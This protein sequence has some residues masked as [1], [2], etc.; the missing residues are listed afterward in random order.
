[1]RR[2]EQLQN[3]YK[4]LE[5]NFRRRAIK[6][7]SNTRMSNKAAIPQIVVLDVDQTPNANGEEVF[8]P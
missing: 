3:L 8:S 4:R 5:R 6:T 1:M 2:L 7:E